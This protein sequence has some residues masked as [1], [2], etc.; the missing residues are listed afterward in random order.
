MPLVE[1]G[2]EGFASCFEDLEDPRTGNA[3][4]HDPL[5]FSLETLFIAPCTV[6]SGGQDPVFPTPEI[7]SV[8]HQP[9]SPSGGDDAEVL[10]SA[11]FNLIKPATQA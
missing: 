5:D 8:A 6:L 4:L 9:I 2:A 10:A 11:P 1:A 3:G 7:R